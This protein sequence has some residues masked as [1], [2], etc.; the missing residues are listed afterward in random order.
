MFAGFTDEHYEV[1]YIQNA[2]L[3]YVTLIIFQRLH[4]DKHISN[5]STDPSRVKQFYSNYINK[6]GLFSL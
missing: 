6:N 1:S 2:I 4:L 5:I 3:Q